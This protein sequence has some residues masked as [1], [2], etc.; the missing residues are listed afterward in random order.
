MTSMMH[1]YLISN[2]PSCCRPACNLPI[3]RYDGESWWAR[4]V[5]KLC[6]QI[7]TRSGSNRNRV[8]FDARPISV[9]VVG[10]AVF[11]MS[12]NVYDHEKNSK[13]E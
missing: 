13:R 1:S 9:P 10:M 11:A 5:R 4:L 12:A 2:P 6:V 7:V 8:A 3:S